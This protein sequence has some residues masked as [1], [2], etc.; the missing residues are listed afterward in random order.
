MLFFAENDPI[1]AASL[2]KNGSYSEKIDVFQVE[3][4]NFDV[5]FA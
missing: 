5:V 1:F 3:V 4:L 2:S